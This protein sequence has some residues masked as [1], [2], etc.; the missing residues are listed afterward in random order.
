M[1]GFPCQVTL[2]IDR[3]I[4][5]PE[6]SWELLEKSLDKISNIIPNKYYG[7]NLYPKNFWPR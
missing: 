1:I 3:N 4:E 7:V 5:N 6:D 2:P